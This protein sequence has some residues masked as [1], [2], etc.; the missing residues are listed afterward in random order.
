M[1]V[2]YWRCIIY[3]TKTFVF[4]RNYT[5][6]CSLSE[7]AESNAVGRLINSELK[8]IR[9]KAIGSSWVLKVD[10][11]L[12]RSGSA[13]HAVRK[14]TQPHPQPPAFSTHF[15]FL[16]RLN[17]PLFWFSSFPC[18]SIPPTFNSQIPSPI[19][20]HHRRSAFS[21]IPLLLSSTPSRCLGEQI[22]LRKSSDG[23]FCRCRDS[24]GAAPKYKTRTYR[25]IHRE[26]YWGDTCRGEVKDRGSSLARSQRIHPGVHMAES[27]TCRE[28][29]Q[30]CY[31]VLYL[32]QSSVEH[33]YLVV[34]QMLFIA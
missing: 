24:N 12:T 13:M 32:D 33:D 3:Y 6:M 23:G 26:R 7:T 4:T 27:H 20:P 18:S 2:V 14:S 9:K 28:L 22:K 11:R 31:S 16:T 29:C 8:T 30:N 1:Y 17:C 5:P 15:N 19:N 34:I 21:F 25:L 10:S